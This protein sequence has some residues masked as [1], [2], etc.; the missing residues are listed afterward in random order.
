MTTP[1]ILEVFKADNVT[2]ARIIDSNGE[3]WW[4]ARGSGAV[5]HDFWE[6]NA[7]SDDFNTMCEF[8]VYVI[9]AHTSQFIKII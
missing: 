9:K 3:E 7:D 8:M 5:Y 2:Y 4:R 1:T 6:L